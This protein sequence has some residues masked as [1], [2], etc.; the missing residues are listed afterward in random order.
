LYE[1]WQTDGEKIL[2]VRDDRLSESASYINLLRLW[3]IEIDLSTF[4]DASPADVAQFDM[5]AMVKA[6]QLNFETLVTDNLG[7]ALRPDLPVIVQLSGGEFAGWTLIAAMGGEMLTVVDPLHGKR[8]VR[9]S[10]LEPLVRRA[11]VLFRDSVG[12]IGIQPGEASERV[13]V[14]QAWLAR[15][16]Y[17]VGATDGKFGAQ[18]I[19]A[20]RKLQEKV[21]LEPTGAMNQATVAYLCAQLNPR[22]PSLYS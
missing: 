12:L 20:L 17:Y 1:N 11:I 16:G 15:E 21:G 18:T 9:R 6:N 5:L 2:R 13:Q 22:R 4:R 14:L 10:N 8:T 7:E 3:N 19:E